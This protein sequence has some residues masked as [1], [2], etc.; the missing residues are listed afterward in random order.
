M[1]IEHLLCARNVLGAEN[2]AG[3]KRD[4]VLASSAPRLGKETPPSRPLPGLFSTSDPTPFFLLIIS[5]NDLIPGVCMYAERESVLTERSL[6][7]TLG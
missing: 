4:K 3:N 5:C 2:R 6:V 7:S 1:F